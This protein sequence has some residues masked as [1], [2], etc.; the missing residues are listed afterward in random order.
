[1]A[2]ALWQQTVQA[3]PHNPDYTN[4][5]LIAQNN[6]RINILVSVKHDCCDTYH[7]NLGVQVYWLQRTF[8][9][10][11]T[12]SN[13]ATP[14]LSIASRKVAKSGKAGTPSPHRPSRV[15]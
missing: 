7:T 8:M 6:K 4:Y 3:S 13:A 2:D 12:S 11:A 5:I 15:M 10:M 9:S 1:M 14:L